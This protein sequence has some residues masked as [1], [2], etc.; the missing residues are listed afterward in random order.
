MLVSFGI[1]LLFATECMANVCGE[2]VGNVLA[3][4]FDTL[5]A[6]LA[7]LAHPA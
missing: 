2:T 3:V 7:K 5:F 4:A 1:P 6:I